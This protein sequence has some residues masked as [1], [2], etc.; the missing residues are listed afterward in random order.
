MPSPSEI[1]SGPEAT[2]SRRRWKGILQPGRFLRVR[3]LAWAIVFTAVL[4]FVYLVSEGGAR[5]LLGTGPLEVAFAA[6]A[7]LVALTLY[8]IAVWVVE[9]RTPHEL[10]WARLVPELGGGLLLGAALFA[11]VMGVLVVIGAYA[12]MGPTPAPIWS[13]LG[14][15][16]RSG[17][18]EELL[19][20]GIILRLL[21]TAFG[22]WPAVAVSSALF[23]LVHL[24]NPHADVLIA[25]DIA[26]EAGLPLG[27]LYVLTGRLWLPIG[28]HIA[29]NFTESYV[30]GA[31]LS[32]FGVP[33]SL[34][35]SEAVADFGAFWTGGTFG[36][37]ASLPS[38]V[39]GTLVGVVLV[40]MIL[41]HRRPAK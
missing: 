33:S 22:M 32:G 2:P 12:V 29:W 25:L 7:V 17:V 3:T 35:R 14:I 24:L 31:Q 8:V 18:F 19:F 6:A 20:R 41:R 9:R 13:E 5:V 34:F 28:Y 23:G 37:E 10:S 27:A 30:F 11:A 4:Q 26:F 15:S 21:W 40:A 38:V 36:P 39:L 1:P 16:L